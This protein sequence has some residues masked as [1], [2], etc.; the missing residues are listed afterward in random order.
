MCAGEFTD[1]RRG[2]A[3][4]SG[5]GSAELGEKLGDAVAPVGRVGVPDDRGQLVDRDGR[6][7][8]VQGLFL[9]AALGGP[10][11]G[12]VLEEP[13]E[14]RHPV[15]GAVDGQLTEPATDPVELD[16][17]LVRDDVGC[18]AGRHRRGR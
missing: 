4:A 9:R 14:R 8:V 11:G 3:A 16:A 7:E 10:A 13:A 2:A 15:V 5:Q 18:A 12:E 6:A 1:R 17:C